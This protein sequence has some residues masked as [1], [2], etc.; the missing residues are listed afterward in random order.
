MTVKDEKT[1][2][3]L[4]AAV[5][6]LREAI[7]T[8]DRSL[9]AIDLGHLLVATKDLIDRHVIDIDAIFRAADAKVEQVNAPK[10]VKKKQ[11]LKRKSA[12]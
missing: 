12:K 5:V 2:K 7:S 9:V 8:G 1:F 3:K 6:D 4:E 11:P 10:K